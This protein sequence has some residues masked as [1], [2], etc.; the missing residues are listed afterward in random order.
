MSAA[1]EQIYR[2]AL[3]LFGERG[4][5][6]VNVTE[7]A[8]AAGVARGTIYNNLGDL[9]GLFDHVAVE[10]AAE[11]R[12]RVTP[13]LAALEEPVLRLATGIRLHV[14]SATDAPEVGRF[15][16]RFGLSAGALREIWTGQPLADLRAG[17]DRGFY[18][19]PEGQ[20]HSVVN[21]ISGAAIGAMATALERPD[22]AAEAAM[23]A[24][25][26]V[27]VALGVPRAR[28]RQ[29]ARVPLS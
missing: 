14:L 10:L 5:T 1:N 2:A 27:L 9:T 20:L 11:M 15:L 18:N 19:F 8:Q 26:L 13:V 12:A 7:L 23:E 3:K 6:Q 28:A 29:S 16:V 24:A 21:F 17:R 25:E 22:R 4:A